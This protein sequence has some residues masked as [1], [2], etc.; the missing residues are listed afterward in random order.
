ML[1]YAAIP[2]R[3]VQPACTMA[4]TACTA[5]R[6][7]RAARTSLPI[8]IRLRIPLTTSGKSLSHSDPSPTIPDGNGVGHERDDRG[9]SVGPRSPAIAAGGIT[10]L[11]EQISRC[12]IENQGSGTQPQSDRRF[13]PYAGLPAF[14]WPLQHRVRVNDEGGKARYSPSVLRVSERVR[15]TVPREHP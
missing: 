7:R 3:M 6:H 9:I 11:D 15:S 4:W 5:T 12:C 13:V 2:Y 8:W 14:A 1:S 10:R